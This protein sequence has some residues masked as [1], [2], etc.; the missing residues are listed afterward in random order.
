ML[1]EPVA[2][3]LDVDDL[4]VVQQAVEDRGGD[5]GIPE[6]FLPVGEAFVGGDDGGA[7][8]VAVGDE[9]EEQIRLAA[10][11][12]Q[13]AHLVDHHQ[14]RGQIGLVV[15]LALL[16]F[17]DQ[18]VHG[19]EIDL[20]AVRA[21]LD[22]KGDRQMGF[23][24]PRRAQEDDILLLG[25]E[26]HVEERHDLLLVQLG[27]EAEVVLID[28]LGGGKPGG[29]HGGLEAALLLDGH[30]LLQQLIQKGQIR[31]FVGLGLLGDSLQHF[32]GPDQVQT[33]EIVAEAVGDQLVHTPPP[34]AKRSYSAMGRYITCGNKEPMDSPRVAWPLKRPYLRR[35]CSRS[36]LSNSENSGLPT[37]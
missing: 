25:D 5:H 28:A 37:N 18:S 35:D 3:A 19:G 14:G 27:M 24:H 13:V 22:G 31:A 34:S 17:P 29:L 6:E 26:V 15:R 1:P 2:V 20:E 11:D 9:L 36:A 30:F 21:G 12:G 23:T 16:E 33:R 7:A 4:A 10:V 8:L 32:G